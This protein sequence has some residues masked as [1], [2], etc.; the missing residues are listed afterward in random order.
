MSVP[1][2]LIP[3][4]TTSLPEY[5]GSSTL[6]YFPYVIDGRTYKVREVVTKD[7]GM[8]TFRAVARIATETGRRAKE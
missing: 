6:G 1:T 7:E 4:K 5:T 3:T 2:N 8:T